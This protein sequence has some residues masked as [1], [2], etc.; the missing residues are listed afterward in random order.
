MVV[1]LG[2][3]LIIWGQY[4]SK[5][6]KK[7]GA[8]WFQAEKTGAVWFQAEKKWGHYGSKHIKN[9]GQYGSKQKKMVPSLLKIG[10]SMVPSRKK[11]GQYGSKEKKL[12]GS[13][14]PSI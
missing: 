4:G 9:W 3:I 1:L 8:L 6:K 2:E 12:G 5:Q 10:S 13:M 11:W 7:M 14:V